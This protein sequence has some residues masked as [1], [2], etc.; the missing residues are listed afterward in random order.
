[1]FLKKIKMVGSIDYA[2]RPT[3]TILSLSLFF[4]IE[5]KRFFSYFKLLQYLLCPVLYGRQF[6][7][8]FSNVSNT[9]ILS[10]L[11][12]LPFKIFALHDS[13]VGS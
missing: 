5:Q 8:N 13:T 10:S 3:L 1:M 6:T 7:K 12:Y 11:I 2:V 9:C 4:A